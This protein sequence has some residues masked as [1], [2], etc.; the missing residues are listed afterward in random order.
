[1]STRRRRR[2]RCPGLAAI[3]RAGIA[4]SPAGCRIS[5]REFHCGRPCDG[6]R[7][8]RPLSSSCWKPRPHPPTPTDRR[9]RRHRFAVDRPLNDLAMEL[10]IPGGFGDERIAAPIRASSTPAARMATWLGRRHFRRRAVAAAISDGCASYCRVAISAFC[11]RPPH[12]RATADAVLPLSEKAVRKQLRA[13]QTG[14]SG[15]QP[16]VLRGSC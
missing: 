3:R 6:D 4:R 2:K 12:E 16:D 15:R 11:N 9:R 8:P 13:E 1:M 14:S 10:G 5:L 7:R